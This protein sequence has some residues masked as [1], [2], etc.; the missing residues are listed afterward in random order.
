MPTPI[1]FDEVTN[2]IAKDQPE[3]IPLPSYQYQADPQGTVVFCWQFTPDEL[4]AIANNDGKLWHTVLTF[5][6]PLQPIMLSAEKPTMPPHNTPPPRRAPLPCGCDRVDPFDEV[7]TVCSVCSMACCNHCSTAPREPI[8]CLMCLPPPTHPPE[9]FPAPPMLL[10]HVCGSPATSECNTC[11]KPACDAH[12]QASDDK[13]NPNRVCTACEWPP[14]P[15]QPGAGEA[16][17]SE[18]LA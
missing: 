1:T 16:P 12:S 5:G 8:I 15:W 3:Y 2:V 18:P 14:Y 6:H 7:A 11:H 4:L 10:C 13:A 9:P 17:G